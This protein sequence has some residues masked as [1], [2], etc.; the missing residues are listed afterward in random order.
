M[1]LFENGKEEEAVAYLTESFGV[2]VRQRY[3]APGTQQKT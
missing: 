1:L 3:L 2:T